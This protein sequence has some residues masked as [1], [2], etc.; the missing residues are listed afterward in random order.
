MN[1]FSNAFSSAAE[2][3][4][5]ADNYSLPSRSNLLLGICLNS[6]SQTGRLAELERFMRYCFDSFY[7]VIF[8]IKEAF[9]P[10]HA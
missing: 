8:E 3:K 1:N 4:P 5:S 6:C 2:I 7:S 10:N 9:L